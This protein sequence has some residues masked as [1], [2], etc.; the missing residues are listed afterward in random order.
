MLLPLHI[1]F[2]C[3]P[4]LDALS[5]SDAV[6]EFMTDIDRYIPPILFVAAASNKAPYYL[7]R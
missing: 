7:L 3:L 4:S 5:P 6:T 2:C 1:Y